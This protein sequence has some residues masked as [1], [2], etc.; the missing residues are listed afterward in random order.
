MFD[1]FLVKRC[2]NA[3]LHFVWQAVLA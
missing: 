2:T 1:I 3:N